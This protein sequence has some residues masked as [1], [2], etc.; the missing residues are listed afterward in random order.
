MHLF[1]LAWLS[2]HPRVD[3]ETLSSLQSINIWDP[4][5]HGESGKNQLQTGFLCR[6]S[7]KPCIFMNSQRVN[8]VF[9]VQANLRRLLF[10]PGYPAPFALLQDVLSS[11]LRG[12]QHSDNEA[13]RP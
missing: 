2:Q 10:G 4:P 12:R 1:D 3:V 7:Q 11:V 9:Q 6:A 13:A 8:L 5:E